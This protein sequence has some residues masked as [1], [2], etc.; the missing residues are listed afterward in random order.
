MNYYKNIVKFAKNLK[1]TI[2]KEFGSEPVYNEKNLQVKI[3]SYKGKININFDNNKIPKEGCQFIHSLIILIDSV[4]RAGKKNY[5]PELFLEE[6]KCVVKGKK[7]P[8]H[9]IDNIEISFDSDRQ[10]SEED[11]S[12]QD[13]SD[14]EHSNEENFHEKILKRKIL[15]ILI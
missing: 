1:K 13:N 14:E 15:K 5:Y 10:N 8:K 3:K 11:N 6:C 7:I 4:F 2:K 9:I 12:D